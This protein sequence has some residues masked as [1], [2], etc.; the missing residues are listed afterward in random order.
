MDVRNHM[1]IETL[2]LALLEFKKQETSLLKLGIKVTTFNNVI[3]YIHKAVQTLL[4]QS[5]GLVEDRII[6]FSTAELLLIEEKAKKGEI[7]FAGHSLDIPGFEIRFKD[8]STLTKVYLD[9][10]LN[11]HY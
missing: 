2:K 9:N 7:D 6:L 10:I 1:T 5:Y 11:T 3:E 8:G 4:P